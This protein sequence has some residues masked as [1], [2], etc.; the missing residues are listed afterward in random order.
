MSDR[1]G[2][3]HHVVHD[4]PKVDLT[5]PHLDRVDRR[6][7]RRPNLLAENGPGFRDPGVQDGRSGAVYHRRRSIIV[8]DHRRR[9]RTGWNERDWCDDT[10]VVVWREGSELIARVPGALPAL[11]LSSFVA[12]KTGEKEEEER[13]DPGCERSSDDCRSVNT[14]VRWWGGGGGAERRSR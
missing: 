1:G 7:R 13:N 2:R 4:A 3:A 10:V 5:A 14:G 11:S 8:G 9:G 6:G 12:D